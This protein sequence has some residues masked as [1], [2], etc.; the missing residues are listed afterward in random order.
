MIRVEFAPPHKIRTIHYGLDADAMPV[1]PDIR[2]SLRAELGLAPKTLIVGSVCRLIEQK[3]LAYA[4]QAFRQI[5]DS[6]AAHYVIIGD[7]PLRETLQ[8]QAASVEIAD[9]VHFLGWRP[10]ARAYYPAF[11]VFLMP[12]LWEGFGLVVLEAMAARLPVIASKVSALPEIVVDGTTGYHTVPGDADSIA[13]R[14][15]ILL[16]DTTQRSAMGEAGFQRLRTDFS[17]QRMIEQT[18]QV[19]R[20]THK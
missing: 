4:L 17:N 10:N 3:G 13:R 20:D 11:D 14:L 1:H 9:R 6:T 19:Y 2:S 16:S 8:A 18:V 15:H 7:G 12:S 5:A